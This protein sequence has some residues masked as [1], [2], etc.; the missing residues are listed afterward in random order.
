[1]YF[2]P[3]YGVIGVNYHAK[4]GKHLTSLH[5]GAILRVILLIVCGL[6]LCKVACKMHVRCVR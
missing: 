5:K 2:M 3:E 1:M 4:V 6:Q